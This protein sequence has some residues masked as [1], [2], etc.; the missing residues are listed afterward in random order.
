MKNIPVLYCKLKKYERTSKAKSED[1]TKKITR[2]YM[3]P[4]K[5]EQIEDTNFEN[6]EDIVILSKADFQKEFQGSQDINSNVDE[7]KKSLSE[8]DQE[9][10]NLRE[11]LNEKDQELMERNQK[12]RNLSDL[13]ESQ[14]EELQ[15]DIKKINDG[16]QAEIKML[17]NDIEELNAIYNQYNNLNTVNKDLEREVKRLTDLRTLEKESLRLKINEVEL[18]KDEYD[19]LKKSHELLWDVV[20]E[21]D[22][23]I[24]ELEKGGVMGNILKKIRKKEG[25]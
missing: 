3:I 1:G 16:Y 14:I 5:K 17:N 24:K 25:T 21:K 19:K 7:L 2:R 8:K 6:I 13:H 10:L 22:K 9:I 23:I 12:I 4:V 15:L 18:T 20:Q 11:L